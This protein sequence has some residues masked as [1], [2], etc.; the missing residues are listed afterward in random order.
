MK[1][2]QFA[3]PLYLQRHNHLKEYKLVNSLSIAHAQDWNSTV[4]DQLN[5]TVRSK[6]RSF[7]DNYSLFDSLLSYHTDLK[8][9]T[10]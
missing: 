7:N 8:R 5:Y 4:N 1:P 3:S 9:T 6:T 10:S 2:R